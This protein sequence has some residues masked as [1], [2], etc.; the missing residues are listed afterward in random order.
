MSGI[1]LSTEPYYIDIQHVTHNACPITDEQLRAWA[2]LTLE[3]YCDRAELTIRLVE[4]EEIQELNHI[5]RQKNTPTNVLA[6]PA[7]YPKDIALDYP[8]L[9]DIIICAEVLR[10]E[11]TLSKTPLTAHWAHIVIH[12]ILHLLGYDHIEDEAATEMQSIEIQL[13]AT[14]NIDNPYHEAN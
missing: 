13:L 3:P 12:G 11:S 2:Q 7:S 14:L 4:K 10:E 6:F 1:R 8:L 5:Y 9:G